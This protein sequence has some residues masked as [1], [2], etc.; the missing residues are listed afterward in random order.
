MKKCNHCGEDYNPEDVARILG[1]QSSALAGGFCSAQCYT[2]DLMSYPE[3]KKMR[4][5]QD[6]SQAL[7]EF[8]DWLCVQ[9]INLMEWK[10][11]GEGLDYYI[12]TESIESLL[13]RHFDIDLNKVEKEKQHMLDE[14]RSKE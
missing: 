8:I 5:I 11:K 6:K 10:D 12:I 7:G 2:K 1:E 9:G 4:A 13:A 14:L 3:C